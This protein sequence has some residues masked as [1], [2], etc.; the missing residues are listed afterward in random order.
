VS[1]RIVSNFDAFPIT[2]SKYLTSFINLQMLMP[3]EELSF[4]GIRK[5]LMDNNNSQSV[6]YIPLNIF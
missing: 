5:T 3:S 2:N 1:E 4:L 6:V